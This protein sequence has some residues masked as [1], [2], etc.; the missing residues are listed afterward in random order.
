MVE[1]IIAENFE[2]YSLSYDDTGLT[3]SVWD[4]DVAAGT[5][6][7]MAGNSEAQDAWDSMKENL[8]T[9]CSSMRDLLDTAGLE[10]ASVTLN[11][12]NDLNTDNILLCIIDGVPIYD[13]TVSS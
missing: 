9:L 5:A 13:A 6:L 3:L 2:H 11:L 12:L 7:V 1:P 8:I 10:D 4:D